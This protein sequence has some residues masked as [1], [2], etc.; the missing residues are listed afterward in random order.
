MSALLLPLAGR[1]GWGSPAPV[2]LQ[3]G[4]GLGGVRHPCRA[5][6]A[7]QRAPV[8]VPG[9]FGEH[10]PRGGVVLLLALDVKD[11]EGVLTVLW[12][13]GLL[14]VHSWTSN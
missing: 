1:C 9:P 14:S 3:R 6:Q 2:R 10:Q 11:K 13:G 4:Q 7:Q 12:G 8:E 5:E